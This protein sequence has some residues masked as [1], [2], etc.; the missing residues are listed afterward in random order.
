MI[1][2]QID[3]LIID[4]EIIEDFTNRSLKLSRKGYFFSLLQSS[5]EYLI[6]NLTI[7]QLDCNIKEYNTMLNKELSVIHST[8]ELILE[9]DL[10]NAGN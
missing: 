4:L 1:K 3:N 6:S 9:T 8:P 7:S 5:C 2:S 10:I